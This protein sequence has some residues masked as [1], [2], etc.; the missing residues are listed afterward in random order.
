ME[1]EN[2]TVTVKIILENKK[3]LSFLIL[4]N[5]KLNHLIHKV[6]QLTMLKP[7]NFDLLHLKICSIMEKKFFISIN[8]EG[9]TFLGVNLKN[10]SLY[11]AISK[12]L[13]NKSTLLVL[14]LV[15]KKRGK[16]YLTTIKFYSSLILLYYFVNRA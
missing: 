9:R 1:I 13:Q 10:D 2:E 16:Y 8:T 4:K 5:K 3:E 7:E 6:S 12:F 14:N 15:E 11:P